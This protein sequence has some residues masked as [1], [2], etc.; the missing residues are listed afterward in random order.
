MFFFWQR[1]FFRTRFF[2][3]RNRF[4]GPITSTRTALVR[5]LFSYDFPRKLRAVPYGSYY[6][7]PYFTLSRVDL[8]F[9]QAHI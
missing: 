6:K 3:S 8:G 2:Y 7:E 4:S 9:Q 1:N 5:D